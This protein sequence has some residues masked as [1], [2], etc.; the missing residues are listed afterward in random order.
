M[1]EDKSMKME[2]R[3]SLMPLLGMTTLGLLLFST[4]IHADGNTHK[5]SQYG[6][7]KKQST[8]SQDGGQ[9]RQIT[10]NAGPTVHN[11]ADIFI[12]ANFIYWK[13]YQENLAYAS[14]IDTGRKSIGTD[15]GPG[16]K[17]GIGLDTSHDGWDLYAEYTWNRF[18]QSTSTT[19]PRDNTGDSTITNPNAPLVI[20]PAG[21][22]ASAQWKLGF[23]KIDLMLGRNFFLSQY[24][25]MR[26]SAGLTGTWQNQNMSTT[27][28]MTGTPGYTIHTTPVTDLDDHAYLKQN[29]VLKNYGI[30]LRGGSDF[31][32]YFTKQ[33]SIFTDL[34]GNLYWTD[35]TTQSNKLTLYDP[36]NNANKVYI[37]QNND[38]FYAVKFAG[39]MEIGL[40]WETYFCEHDYHFAIRAT[41][42]MQTW[43]NWA[44]WL[45]AINASDNND[46]SFQG[47]NLKLRFDF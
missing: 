41:W 31:A 42:E 38:D 28:R 20:A 22:T 26:P 1:G 23:N 27:F 43:V 15:W 40:M 7:E 46:L 6:R 18:S 14:R 16:F 13:A 17:V 39:E 47:L 30:G 24:L 25:T 3:K 5:N 44:R 11:G 19:S 29:L 8:S 34:Y 12:S 37:D 32:W 35:Y 33:F 36:T 4:S 10:P 21:D 45:Q 2:K 9:F